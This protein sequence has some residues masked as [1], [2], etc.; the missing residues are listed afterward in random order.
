MTAKIGETISKHRILEKIDEGGTGV[1]F[2]TEDTTL[3][4]TVLR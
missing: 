1:V 4:L 3:R 2:K